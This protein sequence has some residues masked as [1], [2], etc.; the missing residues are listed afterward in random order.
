[1]TD[2]KEKQ[3][4]HYSDDNSDFAV[5]SDVIPDVILEIRYYSTFNFI[6]ERIDG[7][8]EPTALLTKKAA[9]ALKKVSDDFIRQGYRLKIFDAYRPQQA[10]DHF[11]RWAEDENDTRMRSYFYPGLNKSELIP[12]GYIARHSGHTRGSTVDLTLFDM[13][14]GKDVDM[15]GEFDWFGEVSHPD[16]RRISEEQYQNRLLLQE[17]ME[18]H[19]FMPID[20]EWWH[21]T[22][23]DE[24]YPDTYFTFPVKRYPAVKTERKTVRVVAAIIED[25]GRIFATQR[26]YGEFKDGWEFPGGKIEANETPP[27]ALR[28][29]IREELKTEIEVGECLTTIEY[30]YPDF[31]LSMNCYW[32]KI[33][34]G[35]P[36]LLEHE[37]ARWLRIEELD[38]VDWLLADQT[39]IELIKEK[40]G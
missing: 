22:L 23:K 1:M 13:T 19:G 14:A 12:G 11:M 33:I 34:A 31:H 2:Q 29:E 8:E 24:P 40:R 39:I 5:I 20:S 25:Q 15:G 10:V 6:G 3:Q 32:A 26:G 35:E 28:R 38:T 7:Y 30:D 9:A 17:G 4:I 36:V 21:F 18:R 27:Q 16:C 37:A